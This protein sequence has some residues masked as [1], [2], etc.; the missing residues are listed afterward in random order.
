MGNQEGK[1]RYFQWLDECIDDDLIG[2][3]DLVTFIN[4]S[5][6]KR[7]MALRYFGSVKQALKEYGFTDVCTDAAWNDEQ[8]IHH[9]YTTF[10]INIYGTLEYDSEFF[11]M[12]YDEYSAL[13][14]ELTETSVKRKLN[15]S[16]EYD[17]LQMFFDSFSVEAFK[18]LDYRPREERPKEFASIAS[19]IKYRPEDRNELAKL[20]GIRYRAYATLDSSLARIKELKRLGLEFQALVK[21]VY[22]EITLARTD[23]TRIEDC[24]PDFISGFTWLDAKL[25]KSTAT[26]ANIRKYRKHTDWLIIVYAIDDGAKPIDGAIYTHVSEY[27][28]LISDELK[29]KIDAFI[30][31]ATEVRFGVINRNTDGAVATNR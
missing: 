4:R 12:K 11:L 13:G 23:Q 29:R 21:D 31:K 1:E 3:I 5:S 10:N 2:D 22:D 17:R 15:A 24:I 16:L 7:K 19:V 25:S 27:Y 30:R 14:G 28:P 26:V 20:F 6:A 18:W 8:T 9:F